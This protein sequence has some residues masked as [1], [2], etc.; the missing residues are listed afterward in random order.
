MKK[1]CLIIKAW[2][3]LAALIV[4]IFPEYL[5]RK[6]FAIFSSFDDDSESS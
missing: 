2:Q 6:L 4:V 1:I 5:K 3:L